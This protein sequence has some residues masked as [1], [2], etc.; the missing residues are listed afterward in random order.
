MAIHPLSA[1]KTLCQLAGWRLSN[2]ELQKLLYLSHMVCMGRTE[3]HEHLV[4]EP[5]EAWAYGPVLPS[6]YHEVKAFGAEPVGDVFRRFQGAPEGSVQQQSL[7]LGHALFGS[8]SGPQ[9]IALTHSHGSAWDVA[10]ERGRNVRLRDSDILAEYEG[11]L[12]D[13]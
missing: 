8:L 5:F 3:G 1:A 10:Y 2:L 6:V 13:E 7:E 4:D 12:G 9:L 11:L